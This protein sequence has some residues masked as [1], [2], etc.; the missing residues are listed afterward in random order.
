MKFPKNPVFSNITNIKEGL[1]L[2]E[3]QESTK[4]IEPVSTGKYGNITSTESETISET[5]QNGSLTEL[6]D[7]SGHYNHT[8]TCEQIKIF[9]NKI[10]SIDSLKYNNNDIGS[11]KKNIQQNKNKLHIDI[12]KII[13][14]DID[15]NLIKNKLK[16]LEILNLDIIFKNS[17]Y[18][19]NYDTKTDS[20]EEISNIL[21]LEYYYN[22]KYK[23]QI[24][25]TETE[26]TILESEPR[27][28]TET[29][30][31]T[32]KGKGKGKGKEGEG[33]EGE[34]EEVGEVG[35]E[36]KEG[37]TEGETEEGEELNVIVS[38][39]QVVKKG[40]RSKKVK[41][42]KKIKNLKVKS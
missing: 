32:G 2:N 13:Y 34:E 10:L 5:S 17:E 4:I 12:L 27:T 19:F 42:I 35:E 11:I 41:N 9:I 21:L 3:K 22:R 33:E 18:N 7:Y 14:Q 16:I 39:N 37:E 40:G 36:G 28:E 8:Y 30:T 15:I 1:S 23:K 38:T 26:T 24:V 29:G 20:L 31:G 6:L 25:N